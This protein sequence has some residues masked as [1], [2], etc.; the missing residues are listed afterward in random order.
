MN[1]RFSLVVASVLA[2][3]ATPFILADTKDAKHMS[4]DE[5]KLIMTQLRAANYTLA[6]AVEAA[7]DH[8]GGVAIGA[9]VHCPYKD[10]SNET[11]RANMANAPAM[12]DV[13][14]LDKNGNL[15]CVTIDAST[16]KIVGLKDGGIDYAAYDGQSNPT[17]RGNRDREDR[18]VASDSMSDMVLR[19]NEIIGRTVVNPQGETLGK[20][21]DLAIDPQQGEVGYAVLSHGGILGVNDKLFAVPWT[22]FESHQGKRCVLD[23]DKATLQNAPGFDKNRWPDMNDLKWNETVHKHYNQPGYWTSTPASN[24]TTGSNMDDT[25]DNSNTGRGAGGTASDPDGRNN[26]ANRNTNHDDHDTNTRNRDRDNDDTTRTTPRT[27]SDAGS[28]N[29]RPMIYRAS[30]VIGMNVENSRDQNIGEIEDLVLHPDTGDIRYAVVAKG[31][32]LGVNEK[33]V[34]VPWSAFS[35]DAQEKDLTLD[36]D[37]ETFDK[38]RGFDKN[39]WPNFA[40][41]RWE[42]DVHRQYNRQPSWR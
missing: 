27:S 31:G 11:T 33:F 23:V 34:A 2:G 8:V 6:E 3:C 18:Y 26:P 1:R 35:Y 40:D 19:A 37:K 16:K 7:Q 36:V 9:K 29:V 42:S 30:D 24:R 13:A 25:G 39:N 14:V 10:K 12:I 21:E 5:A 41:E 32:F 22:A 20:I 17:M 4:A 28:S 38:Y 15:K